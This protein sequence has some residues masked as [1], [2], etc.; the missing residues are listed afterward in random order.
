MGGAVAFCVY[1]EKPD[2]FNGVVF[3]CPMCKISDS[4]LP[5]PIVINTLLKVI[6]PRGA[7][8]LLGYL[9][10]APTK[11]ELR[12]LSYKLTARRDMVMSAPTGFARNPRLSTARELLDT[13]ARIS[14]R[15][16]SFDAPFLVQHGKEDK[17]T[18]PELSQLMYD[19]SS[20]KDKTIKL[21]DG[22]WH[23]LTSGEPEENINLVF[24]D[25][26]SWISKRV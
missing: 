9:P 20:S 4:M 18:D 26:I 2:L 16:V 15:L 17:V 24:N 11:G 19:E 1:Q 6:G 7:N 5:P 3:C 14:K 25:A 23:T 22:M 21:Y 12:N 13:T 8:T 10:I